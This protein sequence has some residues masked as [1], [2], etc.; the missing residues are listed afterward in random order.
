MGKL[1]IVM[2]NINKKAKKE[3]IKIGTEL[4]QI[5][6]VPFISPKIT[7]Q[8]YGGLPLSRITELSGKENSGKTT[9]ALGFIVQFQK[10]YPDRKIVF[11]DAE[12]VLD[13]EWAQLIGVDTEKMILLRPYTESGEE[14][15]Q[16]ILDIVDSGEV[17]LVVLDSIPALIPANQLN[18]NV[19]KKTY[20]GISLAMTKFCR[21]IISKLEENKTALLMLNQLRDDID[22][23][24]NTFRTP[25]GRALKHYSALRLF[26]KKG[27]MLDENNDKVSRNTENPAGHYVEIKVEKT[28]ICKPDRPFS[29]YTLNFNKGIDYIEDTI[30]IATKYDIIIQRGAWYYILDPE[31]G[32][33]LS[34]EEGEDIKFQGKVRLVKELKDN[35][36]IWEDV[37][38]KV[39]KKIT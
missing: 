9:T 6:Q 27:V 18:Q 24:F 21:N 38:K 17:G 23:P 26:T 4:N 3:I 33:I 25:G 13:E 19:D 7:W 14:I 34:D 32:E 5:E 29:S 16:Y 12:T 1:D 28:K 11:V 15:L 37:Y 35:N 2:R 10:L 30:D 22:N 39:N 36:E 8:L 31:T 20:G